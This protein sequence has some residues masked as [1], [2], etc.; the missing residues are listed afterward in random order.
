[1]QIDRLEAGDQL[2]GLEYIQE[3]LMM[4]GGVEVEIGVEGSVIKRSYRWQNV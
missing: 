1:M 4:S 2:G 3:R